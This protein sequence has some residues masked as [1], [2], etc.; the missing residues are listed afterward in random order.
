MEEILSRISRKIYEGKEGE[1]CSTKLYFHYVYGRIELDEKTSNSCIFTGTEGEFTG[2]YHFLRE[3]NELTDTPSI[4]Q[5]QIHK[6]LEFKHP[7]WLDEIIIVTKGNIQEHETKVK[8]TMKKLEE[9][10]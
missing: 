6:T 7:A 8:E 1:I 3:F 9:A 10:G 2:Y 5:E 4:F